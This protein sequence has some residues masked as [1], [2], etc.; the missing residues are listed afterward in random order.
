MGCT[1]PR[2]WAISSYWA[3]VS[4]MPRTAQSRGAEPA[5]RRREGRRERAGLAPLRPPAQRQRRAARGRRPGRCKPGAPSAT[6]P[7]PRQSGAAAAAASRSSAPRPGRGGA[8]G[9]GGESRHPAPLGSAQ[10]PRR[11]GSARCL[12][13]AV[14]RAE[15]GPPWKHCRPR[16][17][18]A[19]HRGGLFSV[20]WGWRRT[21]AASWLRRCPIL[22]PTS[23]FLL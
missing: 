16:K 15:V 18:R 11:E 3:L 7:V 8:G 20:A 4:F 13:A 22:R 10:P 1:C 12:G 19:S 21:L 2:N 9:E 14:P 17:P 5:R 23:R 6:S